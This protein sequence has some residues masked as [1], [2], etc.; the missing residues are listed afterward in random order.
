[1]SAPEQ[2]PALR[3]VTVEPIEPLLLSVK[4]AARAVGMS[5]RK[6][7]DVLYSGAVE[8]VRHGHSRL[9]FT[10]SLRAWVERLRED[11]DD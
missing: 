11:P 9:I 7:R 4:D 10:D 1:M 8:S 3:L 6:F 2:Q 5:E